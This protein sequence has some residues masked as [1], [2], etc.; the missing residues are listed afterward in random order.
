MDY[1]PGDRVFHVKYGEGTVLALEK[2]PRD[3]QVTA[4]FDGYGNRVLYASFA[5]LKKI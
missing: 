4:E 2:G 1:G 3:Y 5:K